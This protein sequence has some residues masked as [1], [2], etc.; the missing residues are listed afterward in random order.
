MSGSQSRNRYK[1]VLPNEHSRVH[2]PGPQ[3]YIH[4]NYIKVSIVLTLRKVLGVMFPG[5]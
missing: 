5:F 2:L 3:N 4:A 1:S